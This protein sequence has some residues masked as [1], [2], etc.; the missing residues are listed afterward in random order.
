[1]Q[2]PFLLQT[3]FVAA[4]Q[5]YNEDFHVYSILVHWNDRREYCFTYAWLIFQR[6]VKAHGKT[7]LEIHFI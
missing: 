6:C 3:V 1:M 7:P 2:Y 5:T 4:V